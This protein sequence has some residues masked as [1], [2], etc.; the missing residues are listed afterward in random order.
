MI[1]L[2]D[3]YDSFVHN[4]ARYIGQLGY[5]RRVVRN[6]EVTI[7]DIQ[8][9]NPTHIILSPGPCTPNEAGIT[10]DVIDHFYQSIPI[11]GICLGHQA[12]GQFFKGVVERAK[13]PMHGKS[14]QI[15]HDGQ[16]IFSYL[17][18]PLTVGRYHSLIVNPK[19]LIPEV[20]V[21]ATSE[22][23]EVMALKHSRYP[24]I[25]LQFHPES[26]LSDGGY[27]LLANFLKIGMPDETV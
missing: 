17:K 14:S 26:V 22:I 20:E 19:T 5:S 15:K 21:I 8:A 4:L 7:S 12:I 16:G 18:S 11:L 25:G 2:I 10:L 3:N 9:I 13:Q 1:L 6:D 24:T 23:G 27:D